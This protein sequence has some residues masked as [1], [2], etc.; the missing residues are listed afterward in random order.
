MLTQRPITF[1]L[2]RATAAPRAIASP[3]VSIDRTRP[4]RIRS[5]HCP[6]FSHNSAI[7]APSLHYVELTGRAHN[8]RSI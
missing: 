7:A 5:Q 4:L 1:R 8:V 3:Y 2:P 6:A